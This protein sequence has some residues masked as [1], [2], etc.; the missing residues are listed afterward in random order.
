MRPNKHQRKNTNPK[1]TM[2]FDDRETDDDIIADVESE[3][4]S[5]SSKEIDKLFDNIFGDNAVD[6]GDV[7]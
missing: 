5:L 2:D 6:I 7:E 4:G 3:F 1:Y